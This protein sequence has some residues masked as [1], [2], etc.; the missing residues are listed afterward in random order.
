MSRARRGRAAA[1]VC[2]MAAALGC[3]AAV[4]QPSAGVELRLDNDQFAFTRGERERWYSH[5]AF[6]AAAYEPAPEHWDATALR[7]LCAALLDCGVDARVLRVLSLGHTIHTPASTRIAEPQPD[8][9]PYAATLH[10][11]LAAVSHGPAVRHTLAVRVGAVGPAALGEPVQNAIHSLIGEPQAR[12]WGGQVPAQP[13]LELA[14][15]RLARVGLPWPQADGV[16]RTMI[17]LGTPLTQASVGAALR[18]GPGAL[19]PAWPGETGL[20]E[21]LRGWRVL[22]GVELR[23]VALDALIDARG[24]PYAS[25]V[26]HAP[27]VGEAFAGVGWPLG[28]RWTLDATVVWR[29]IDFES[30]ARDALPGSQRFGM[31]SLRRGS[32]R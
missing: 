7:A 16:L 17:Q 31:L 6:L 1:G 14:W 21:R 24:L 26:T 23:A 25:G 12:G 10:A 13:L 11:G 22:A 9:R 19:E 18:Y 32:V 28:D 30:P 27:W 20:P 8:D 15:S 2:A 3:A 5:G 4:G 29:T